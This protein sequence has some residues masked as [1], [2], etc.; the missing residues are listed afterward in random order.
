MKKLFLFLTGVLLLALSWPVSAQQPVPAQ[1]AITEIMYNPP[2]SGTDTL[3]YLEL[4]N[5]GSYIINLQGYT[6][7]SGIEHTFGSLLL[8]PGDYLIMALNSTAFTSTFGAPAIQ[9]SAGRL[10]NTGETITLTDNNGLLVDLVEYGIASPWPVQPNGGGSSLTLCNPWTDNSLAVNWSA[11]SNPA[12]VNGAG[13]TIFADPM[14]GCSSWSG[15]PVANFY[16]ASNTIATGESAI[17]QDVSAGNPTAWVWSFTGGNPSSSTL[18]QPPAIQ[19]AQ[20]GNYQVC[21]TVVNGNGSHQHC[22][23][24]YISVSTPPDVDIVISEI[25][26]N[27]PGS[28]DS[29]EYIEI[30]NNG[31]DAA[32]LAGYS[33]TQGIGFTF[34]SITLQANGYL[35]LAYD[36]KALEATLGIQATQWGSGFLSNSGEAIVLIDPS[37]QVVDS[38]NYSTD[39]PWPAIAAG[40]GPSL[41]LC[42][43]SLDNSLGSNWIAATE[44]AG[45]V[46]TGAVVYGTPGGPCG[47]TIPVAAFAASQT[48]IPENGTVFFTSQSLGYVETYEWTFEGG[49]PPVQ[50]TA[51]PQVTYTTAGSYQV[52]LKVTNVYG[53][54][55]LCLD[56]YVTVTPNPESN[57]TITEIMYNPPEA[58]DSLEYIELH[59]PSNDTLNLSG[60]RVTQGITH[61]FGSVKIEP[62]GFLILARD[63]TAIRNTFGVNS[64]KWDNGILNNAGEQL[65]LWDNFG[66]Q[67]DSVYYLNSAPWDP[68][69]NGNGY[70]LS[71][72]NPSF[73]N[74]LGENWV[75]SFELGAQ[76]TGGPIWATPGS[77][78]NHAVPLPDFSVNQNTIPVGGQV[79]F[80]DLSAGFVAQR[81]WQFEGGT[82]STSASASPIVKYL[83]AGTFKVCLKVQ[84]VYGADSICREAYITATT[85]AEKQLVI[86]EIMYNSPD[87][88]TDSLEFIELYN[89]TPDTLQLDGYRFTSGISH[90]FSPYALAPGQFVSLA[91]DSVAAARFYG[92]PFL[93]WRSGELQNSGET[94]RL[95][96]NY[97]LEI[98]SVAYGTTPPWNSLANGLGSSLVLCN[99]DA[100]NSLPESWFRAFDTV[101]QIANG[102]Y[103]MAHPQAGCNLTR[104]QAAFIA[105]NTYLFPGEENQFTDLSSGNPT[106]W[107]WSFQGATPQ[108][109]TEQ[110]P[111]EIIYTSSGL[112]EVCLKVSNV[113]GSDSLCRPNYV[114]V[115][116]GGS[117]QLAISEIMYNPPDVIEDTLEYIEITNIDTAE[118]DLRGFK[119][120]TGVYFEFPHTVLYPGDKVLVARNHQALFDLTGQ[121]AFQWRNGE[122]LA[123]TGETITLTD[124]LGMVVDSV[125]YRPSL[126]WPSGTDG[127][128]RSLT[129]C[130]PW[131]DNNDPA[132]WIAA[133]DIAGLK[134]NGDTLWG[135][136]GYSCGPSAPII[137]IASTTTT[138]PLNQPVTYFPVDLAWPSSAWM[139]VFQAA[140]TDTSYQQNPVVT[141]Q[142]KG[143][144]SVLLTAYNEFGSQSYYANR[145]INVVEAQSIEENTSP[146]RI[147]PNPTNGPLKI[148][149]N[150][151]KISLIT[152]HNLQGVMVARQNIN[153]NLT[154]FNLTDYP[155]GMYFVTIQAE[156]GTS[157]TMKI[158]RR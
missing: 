117:A 115:T 125:A 7:T 9:W 47:F 156:N 57:L 116:E 43:P 147:Y 18:Q 130:D 80:A 120:T 69:A 25:M 131:L 41:V 29:L 42:D 128:G 104:P 28:I 107:L 106:A 46:A 151:I 74:A 77:P 56:N 45:V 133:Y 1:I 119:I 75:R 51:N 135:T 84:N 27:P 139:W 110:H 100:D 26:Y 149:S 88:N 105:A 108:T 13:Q 153:N 101:G 23:P 99:P 8:Y 73:D 34:P 112:F 145:Y 5:Y 152:I 118:T 53:S 137:R 103:V 89:N 155:A 124:R 129:L 54:D 92:V 65:L 19:Y 11:S 12:A 2:E 62:G 81:S 60:F 22:E 59:N 113:S 91:R 95:V 141:Y 98:D 30:Y 66:R 140:N 97:G 63:T 37:G 93:Q 67:I 3:E 14:S 85:G 35:V 61:T 109:S 38:V 96:D 127:G 90:T 10:S 154:L 48:T 157:Y 15:A 114:R 49:T 138:I 83:T 17:F 134:L 148:E 86:S 158:V 146:F 79:V 78:C 33:F 94:I 102:K 68:A 132:N 136:P 6:F 21:L 31:S 58:S 76:T 20:P 39:S 123:N 44:E 32:N 24:N 72:C 142:Q 143:R 40:N 122:N 71:L 64:V 121:S 36:A 111:G 16:A 144:W 50:N 52:C 87:S 82:P 126:P 70:S 150:N 4:Y 55:Q